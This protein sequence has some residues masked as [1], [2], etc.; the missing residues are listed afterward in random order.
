MQEML[1]AFLKELE[2]RERASQIYDKGKYVSN[3]KVP[4]R[5]SSKSGG[6]G[7]Q[8][9]ASVLLSRK[10]DGRFSNCAFCMGNHQ[11]NV[12]T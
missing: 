11:H 12:I 6:E 3:N 9:T 5:H 10:T 2:L 7:G 8:S 4:K 1:Q